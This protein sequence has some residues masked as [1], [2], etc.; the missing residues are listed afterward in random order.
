VLFIAWSG[1]EVFLLASKSYWASRL[2]AEALGRFDDINAD[3]C[4]CRAA[5]F[6]QLT[7]FTYLTIYYHHIHSDHFDDKKVTPLI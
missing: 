4:G 5:C 1:N 2:Q 3:L 6:C 7:R